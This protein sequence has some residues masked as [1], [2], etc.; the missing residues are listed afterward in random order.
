[1]SLP[2]LT[3]EQKYTRL[4]PA[5]QF[6]IPE[7]MED[8]N[9]VQEQAA[10]IDA[11]WMFFVGLR[12]R[13]PPAYQINLFRDNPISASTKAGLYPNISIDGSQKEC[14]R[15]TNSSK[16]PGSVLVSLHPGPDSGMFI[17]QMIL[18][19][20]DSI[21]RPRHTLAKAGAAESFVIAYK[22]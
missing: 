11:F 6:T 1:M 7:T 9:R 18:R 21:G 5:L 10:E 8:Q 12:G 20:L 3:R 2:I 16:K 4:Q 14:L 22:E 17:F 15:M 13:I 19:S